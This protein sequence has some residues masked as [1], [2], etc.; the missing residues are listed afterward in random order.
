[1]IRVCS[2]AASRL[3]CYMTNTNNCCQGSVHFEHPSPSL[4]GNFGK[5]Q[6]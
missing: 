3:M 5:L 6:A 1:M 2:S 4:L